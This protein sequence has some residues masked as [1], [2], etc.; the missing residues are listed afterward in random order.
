MNIIEHHNTRPVSA[1]PLFNGTEG[2]TVALQ[3][4][5][6]EQLKEH[7]TKVPALLVC[8]SGQVMFANEEGMQKSLKTGDYLKI[9]PQVKHWV[10]AVETSQL[11][12][13]K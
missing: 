5:A 9:T 3:I 2:R 4:Q 7:I 6:G 12:L 8:I 11:I 1:Y 10:D 13:V